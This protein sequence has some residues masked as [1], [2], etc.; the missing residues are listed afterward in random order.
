M[1]KSIL[2]PQF[3]LHNGLRQTFCNVSDAYVA[4]ILTTLVQDNPVLYVAR[5]EKSMAMVA[6]ALKFYG[7]NGQLLDLPAW[8]CLA[9]DRVSPHPNV[10]A[11]RVV[12]LSELLIN[13]KKNRIILTTARGLSQKVVPRHILNGRV[14]KVKIGDNTSLQKLSIFLVEN[15]FRKIGTVREAGEFA[16]RGGIVDIFP[17]GEKYPVRLDFFGDELETIRSFDPTTQ[18]SMK[19]QDSFSLYP[20]SEIL[21]NEDTI[22]QFRQNYRGEFGAIATEDAL[23]QSITAG[24][25]FI[26]YEH[27]Q[28]FY[29]GALETLFE[30]IPLST[31]IVFGSDSN[32]SYK[33]C[34]EDIHEYY[35]VRKT[36]LSESGKE[37]NI[38]RPSHPDNMYIGQEALNKNL[39]NRTV[40]D[41]SAY[42]VPEDTFTAD[43]GACR[44]QD[45]TSDRVQKNTVFESLKTR[46]IDEK[47][48]VL[49]GCDTIGSAE[50]LV[51]MLKDNDFAT[52]EIT[53]FSDVGKIK[54]IGVSVL[55]IE[56]GFEKND[57]IVYSERDLF[58]DKV[59]AV[60]RKSRRS[61]NFLTEA[62]SIEIDDLVVHSS[63]G[64]GRYKGLEIISLHDTHHD[65]LKIM[66]DGGDVVYL[67]IEN[68][69][70]LSRYGS[71]AESV[72]LDRLGGSGWK[73][74]KA[75]MKDRVGIVAEKLIKLAAARAMKKADKFPVSSGLYDEFVA[76]F[77]Y[78]ETDDQNSSINDILEDF[79]KG[80]PMDRLICGDVGFGKTEVA[81]RAT[82]VAVMNG[83]QVAIVAPT[84]LLARQHYKTFVERFEGFPVNIGYMSRLATAKQVKLTKEGLGKGTIDIV[85]GT[86]GVFAKST[87]FSNLGF[88]VVDEEQHFGVAQKETLKNLKENIHVLSLSATPIPRTL[89]MALTGVRDLSIIATPPIDR[90]AIRTFVMPY[91]SV[92]IKESIMRERF[93]GGQVFYVC[94]RVSD[95]DEV[96]RRLKTLVPDMR[97][98]I[99]NGGLPAAQLDEMM[100]DFVDMKYDILLATNIIESGIDIPTANTMI[101]HRADMF[102]LG[103]LYQLRGRIGR[104]KVQAYCYLTTRVGRVLNP[105]SRKRLDVMQ[106]LDSLGAGFQIASHDLDIRGAGN[107]LGDEQSGHI[108]EVGVELYQRMLEEAV[109]SLRESGLDG[110]GVDNEDFS[111]AISIGM[112][113]LIPEHF[114]SDLSQ[115]LSFY[116]RL[117]NVKTDKEVDS[118]AV[119]MVD[120]FGKLPVEVNNLL[121]TVELKVLCRQ[122]GIEKIDAGDKGA[123]IT[124]YKNKVANP[125][126]LIGYMQESLNT[127]RL[128]PDHKVVVA[129]PW[130]NV[131]A[132]LQGVKK[133]LNDLVRIANG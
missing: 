44:V 13:P 123:V 127:V 85:I 117:G 62:S 105:T 108:R 82:F 124:F 2:P 74:R 86:H 15:G 53:K 23:Y 56:H 14:L 50:R 52:T 126:Q 19:P 12:A 113:V 64:I 65:C 32:E 43:L 10:T 49:I 88:L 109:A 1:A 112:S 131:D 40:I 133:V 120:R 7:Y 106:T 39:I 59:G 75:K 46:L 58:G 92:V 95:L 79:E 8:D 128:R 25:S 38:Y 17:S 69:D 80:S 27:W 132:R 55:G 66:Y 121:K 87:K 22:A 122:S 91:D 102:G 71:D 96:S 29:Y 5:D 107:L 78:M 118:I 99:A 77:P 76:R 45:F 35:V 119:E 57:V 48:P 115:R 104:G 63:F 81:L 72:Q 100:T 98:A 114:I 42:Q 33:A 4:Q 6:N 94:P 21:L 111:P 24:I 36:V 93:R 125:A 28:S 110:E 61:E 11:R 26:G 47:R 51:A 68:I 70:M 83:V 130:A 31:Q 3:S 54:G 116:R 30:Y 67:P 97:I 101:V 73:L 37:A 20:A 84:T 103:Q 89:Q 9:Y 18:G 34:L 90:L 60:G 16:V 129:R 41:I